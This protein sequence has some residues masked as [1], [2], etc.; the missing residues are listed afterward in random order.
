MAEQRKQ[1]AVRQLY[2]QVSR[3]F[4]SFGDRMPAW[5]SAC[6]LRFLRPP[7]THG[8]TTQAKMR[9]KCCS[10]RRTWGQYS[11][12]S[13]PT[14]YSHTTNTILSKIKCE[15]FISFFIRYWSPHYRLMMFPYVSVYLY[16]YTYSCMVVSIQHDIKIWRPKPSHARMALYRTRIESRRSGKRKSGTDFD[17]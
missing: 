6:R 3:C 14:H 16:M 4:E 13:V 7:V 9:K 5:E 12:L 15:R 17:T 11:S 2:N 10:G 8:W 1:V